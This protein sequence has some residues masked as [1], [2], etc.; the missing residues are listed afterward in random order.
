MAGRDTS[1][2]SYKLPR[3]LCSGDCAM[4]LLR[5]LCGGCGCTWLFSGNRFWVALQKY[6]TFTYGSVCA[7]VLGYDVDCQGNCEGMCNRCWVRL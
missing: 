5:W 1:T 4:Q 6:M 3:L 2:D 7:Q